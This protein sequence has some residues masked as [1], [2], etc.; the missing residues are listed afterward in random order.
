MRDAVLVS[1]SQNAEDVVLDRLFHDQ[2]AGT[3]IDV[4]ASHPELDSVTKLFYDRGWHGINIEPS[5][6]ELALLQELRPRDV[7]LGVAIGDRP[8]RA[9]LYLGDEAHHGL[10]TLDEHNAERS[11]GEGRIEVEV[12]VLT[13]AQVCEQYQRGPIDFLKI[14]VEGFEAAVVAGAD[15]ERYRPRVLVIE[16]TAPNSTVPTHAQWEPQLLAAGYRCSLFDGLNRFYV[17]ED[18]T[19]ARSACSVPANVHDNFIR[20]D[21]A[22]AR[23]ELAR[24]RLAV[25]ERFAS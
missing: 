22:Q 25:T 6:V 12:E 7:N 2:P 21:L 24:A 9:T 23:A 11:L 17:E 20:F 1:Y 3:Y 18:D 19:E 14:D 4:G 8:G 15:W 10:G 16:A 5:P 13:L